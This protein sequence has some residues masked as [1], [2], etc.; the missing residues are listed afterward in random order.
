MGPWGTNL[1]A[2]FGP[3]AVG[4]VLQRLPPPLDAIAPVL[5]TRDWV[6]V[7]TQL[8]LTEAIVDEYLAGDLRALYPLILE[9]ARAGMGSVQRLLVRTL[10]PGRA[11]KLAPGT[12]RKVHERGSVDVDVSGTSARLRFTGTPLFAHPTW[13]VLQLFATK[14]LLDLADRPGSVTGESGGDDSFVAVASW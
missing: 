4:R 2:R 12:F 1:T 13:R 9:D 6:P 3:D 10:G 14:M 11:M 8:L 5:T 7:Y